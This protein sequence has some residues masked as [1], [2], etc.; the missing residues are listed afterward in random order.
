M[1]LRKHWLNVFCTIHNGAENIIILFCFALCL[2]YGSTELNLNN[3]ISIFITINPTNLHEQY[4]NNTSN[5]FVPAYLKAYFRPVACIEPD[6]ELICSISLYSNGF[7]NAQVSLFTFIC[8]L[9][10]RLL[11]RLIFEMNSCGNDNFIFNYYVH[12]FSTLHSFVRY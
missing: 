5:D 4:D 2:Q 7:F 9:F 12:R 10:I 3:N 6:R 8:Y 1:C 11:K